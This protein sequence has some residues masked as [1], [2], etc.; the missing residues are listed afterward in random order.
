MGKE[1]EEYLEGLFEW[2]GARRSRS[3]GSSSHDPVDITSNGLVIEAEATEAK[4]YGLKLE[5]W[6]EVQRK[7]HTGKLPSLGIRFRD[8][9]EGRHTDLMIMDAHDVAMILEELETYRTEALV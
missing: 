3:S 6:R 7:A 8:A 9:E 5:F 4:S 2:D 1:H